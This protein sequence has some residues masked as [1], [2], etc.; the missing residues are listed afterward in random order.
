MKIYF[1]HGFG[2]N[3]HIFDKI[4]P[5]LSYPKIFVNVW[6]MLG[7]EPIEG[8]NVL[9]FAKVVVEKYNIL[10]E[11]LVI[12]HSMG[13]W[14]AHHIKHFA[15]CPIVQIGS[16]TEKDRV[17]APTRNPKIVYFLCRKR[18]YINDFTLNLFSRLYKGKPSLEIFRDSFIRLINADNQAV[19]NQLMLIFEP[20]E[21]IQTK[22]DL[23][24]HA[25]KDRV[26]KP[27]K[28]TFHLVPGDHFTL[29]TH[30][31]TVIEPILEMI[32]AKT[33]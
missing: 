13:G 23:R 2:E 18:L 21:P 32:R 4:A 17:I 14:I 30:P 28:E 33:I 20:V 25:M 24:I 15:N 3:E 16:W 26:I 1:I 27:P 19:I 29:I 5:A 8:L 11:D 6:E 7:N 12:G 9:N 10:P 31:D 22:P